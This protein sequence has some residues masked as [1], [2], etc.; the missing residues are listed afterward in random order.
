V[1]NPRQLFVFHPK[2]RLCATPLLCLLLVL[3][4]FEVSIAQTSS[5]P[6]KAGFSTERLERY[7]GFL[8]QEIEEGRIAGA[9]SYIVRKGEVAHRGSYGFSNL[10]E[11]TPMTEDNIFHIMSMT[12][13]IIS[14]AFMMLYEEGHFQLN[15][16]LS[17][18]LPVAADLR[19]TTDVTQGLEA[20]TIALEEPIRIAHVLTHT[21]GF[22]H[23]LGGTALDN[24]IARAL[25]LVVATV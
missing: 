20:E 1:I 6:Q 4:Y 16:K 23:G 5:Q 12:K 8:N 3:C 14:V 10:A 7:E 13:P 2:L 19:V 9:V 24:E 22:S 25:Y 17:D 18:Y 21:A 15:D 11:K